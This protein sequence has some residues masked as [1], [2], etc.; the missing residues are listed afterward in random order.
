MSRLARICCLL[1]IFAFCV[2]LR[3]DDMRTGICFVKGLSGNL[4]ADGRSLAKHESFTPEGKTIVSGSSGLSC[5]VFSNRM[6]LVLSPDT[7]LV[8][9]EFKQAPS[10][11]S[12]QSTDN[13]EQGRS[14]LVIKLERGGFALA[15]VT[16]R[17]TSSL[18]LELP[19]CTLTGRTSAMT[20]SLDSA[21][22]ELILLDGNLRMNRSAGRSIILQSRQAL[23]LSRINLGTQS[24]RIR[25]LSLTDEEKTRAITDVAK[26]NYQLVFFLPEGD[27]WQAQMRIVK[28]SSQTAA[29]NDFLIRN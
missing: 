3:A 4:T 19:Q 8:V 25:T 14:Q 10:D 26:N 20:V 15:Q 13:I 24:E 16:P 28:I 2:G 12:A 27:S 29:K 6:A 21:P 1:G 17:A 23:D 5:L 11:G 22:P 7:T 18:T 9:K